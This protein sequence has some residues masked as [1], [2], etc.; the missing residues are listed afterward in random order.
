[1]SADVASYRRVLS[2][3]CARA[4]LDDIGAEPLRLGENAIFTLPGKVVARIARPG[5][6]NAARREVQVARWLADHGVP[7]VMVVEGVEQ[8]VN[9]S[10]R[11]VTFWRQLA[12]HRHGTPAEVA[13]ALHRLHS[14]P[15]PSEFA[16]LNPFTRLPER[17]DAATTL[18]EDDRGW[19]RGRLAALTAGYQDR[20]AGL[21][22]CVVHGDAWV[23][24]VVT[25][26]D[27]RTVLLDLERCSIGPPE[28][29]LVST[30]IKH[31]S[32]GWITAAEYRDFA[33]RYSHDVT[34]WEGF[35]LFRDIRELRMTC[36]LAQH[37]AEHSGSHEE[38]ARRVASLRGSHGPRPWEW[39]PA[40]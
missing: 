33:D 27:G 12:D 18:T 7:A 15:P 37:A 25:T 40:L 24:N 26:T 9:V 6:L 21:A 36:Y 28:W 19:L 5:Q 31:T 11:G 32:F 22:A 29:D 38:A 20:P 39:T 8:P 2:E 34:A 14:L 16:Q 17:I 10:G 23:G 1:M 35:E 30:A 3:A 4:G 13:E